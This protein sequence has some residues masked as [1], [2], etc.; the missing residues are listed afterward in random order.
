MKFVPQHDQMDCGPACLAMV[1][2][3]YKKNIPLNYLRKISYLGRDGVS[4]LG[5]NEAAT[6][7]GFETLPSQLTLRELQE[8]AILPCI[9]H[10]KQNHFVVLYKIKRPFF[11]KKQKFVI[12]D[13][14]HGFISFS[15]PDFL[16]GWL[17]SGKG[18][19]LF[20]EPSTKFYENDGF[21]NR[22]QGFAYLRSIILRYK[23]ELAQIIFILLIGNL[24]SLTF[25]FITKAIIDRGVMNND[26]GII[27]IL[28]LS[29]IFLFI[30]STVLEVIRN[31]IMLFVG[32]KINISFISDFLKKILKLPM[33]FFNTK[34]TG[35]LNQR[36]QDHERIEDFL[37]SQSLTTVFSFVNFSVFFLVLLK[38]NI[39][40]VAVYVGMTVIALI[41]STL[42]FKKREILDYY[43]F[44]NKSD[45]QETIYELLTGIQEIKMNQFETKKR[46]AWEK[47]QLSLFDVNL[48]ILKNT[49]FQTIG[50]GFINQLKNILVTFIAAREVVFGNITLGTML[51]ISY[52]IGQMNSPI[53]QLIDFL[54]S[55]Q[56]ARLSLNR[57]T[58][59][60]DEEEEEEILQKNRD[61]EDT[62]HHFVLNKNKNNGGIWITNLSFQYEGPKSPFV[63]KD[64]D[65]VIPRGKVTAIVGASGSGKS[66][67]MKLILHLYPIQKDNI[68]I[69]NYDINDISPESWRSSCGVVMQDGY[70]FASSIKE[71]IIMG[72]NFDSKRFRESLIIANILDFIESLPSKEETKIGAS[73]NDISGGQKQRILIAR[74]VYRNPKYIFFDEA[75]SALDSENEKII[76]QNLSDFFENRTVLIIA[77]R[78]STVKNADQIIFLK[79]GTIHELGTHE[80]LVSKRSSY[81]NLVKNQLELGM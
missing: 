46:Q 26:L 71:N 31:W 30:G 15:E 17:N 6:K 57:L 47:I 43:R 40:I 18:V 25:P 5:I 12:A 62:L 59:I 68:K 50:F 38:Y 29:Q 44:Q 37:T 1:A 45:N 51:A 36:I 21:E 4:M 13:P 69:E 10:W 14:G 75:T 27:T 63:L 35:D 8:N 73:G 55:F 9:L 22:N 80:E 77:H 42:F 67:L 65:L 72:L 23:S 76:H 20:L 34:L 32:T 61:G 60:Q 39:K 28:L 2:N 3:H 11:R 78:L 53:N 7:I 54:R 64:I 52:I 16:D 70:I 48:R 19:A 66:T 81:Y 24:I 49:Q 58:E 74:A 79:D 33:S 41:W 56:D